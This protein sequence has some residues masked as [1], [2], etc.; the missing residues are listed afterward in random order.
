MWAQALPISRTT[1]AMS[2]LKSFIRCD[3]WQVTVSAFYCMY[4]MCNSK[5]FLY[6]W[7]LFFNFCE[8]FAHVF[9]VFLLTRVFV[10]FLKHVRCFFS[11][12]NLTNDGKSR[13]YTQKNDRLYFLNNHH[14]LVKIMKAGKANETLEI[15]YF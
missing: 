8:L 9:Y 14:L 15:K 10:V 2:T 12:S 3:R 7:T 5:V 1:V 11:L 6:G 4:L 13:S